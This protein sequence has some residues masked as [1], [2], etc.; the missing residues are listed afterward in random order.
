[1]ACFLCFLS[2]NNAWLKKKLLSVTPSRLQ[3]SIYDKYYNL[4]GVVV[5]CCGRVMVLSHRLS[6]VSRYAQ[7]FTM[8]AFN[9]CRGQG[10]TYVIVNWHLFTVLPIE[11]R[12][13]DTNQ[14][15]DFLKKEN[16]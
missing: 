9:I 16:Q 11:E 8:F 5:M 10:F 3:N 15:I 12:T 1:L 6:T 2:P 13:E 7:S 4:E 14:G